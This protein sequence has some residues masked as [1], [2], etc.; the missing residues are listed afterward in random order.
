MDN[1]TGVSKEKRMLRKT[2]MEQV[3][4]MEEAG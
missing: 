3:E 4:S 1:V 2:K